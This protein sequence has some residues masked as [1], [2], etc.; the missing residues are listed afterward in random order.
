MPEFNSYAGKTLVQMKI[1]ANQQAAEIER[2]RAALTEIANEDFRGPRP[3][4]AVLAF[5]APGGG[6]GAVHAHQPRNE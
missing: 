3:H 1:H 2:L 6:I 5:K 4:G